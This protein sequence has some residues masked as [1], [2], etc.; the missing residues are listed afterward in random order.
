VGRI[1]L[2]VAEEATGSK[3][4]FIGEI[5]PSGLVDNI[6]ISNPGWE[7]CRLTDPT[8]NRM[9]PGGFRVHGLYGRV[10]G[11]GKGLIANEP[12]SHPDSIGTPP[13]HPPLTAF[14]G[15]PLVQ[16]GK[17]I[18]LVAVGNR[19]GGYGQEDLATLEALA[20]PI[21]QV[22]MR[23]RAEEALHKERDFTAA[24]LDT[25]GA[26]VIVLDK[27]GRITRFNKACETMTGYTEGEVLGRAFWELLIPQEDLG[28]VMRAWEALQAGNLPTKYENKW[29]A[30]DGSM[31]LIA[32]SNTAMYHPDGRLEH[33]IG[34]GIDITESRKAEAS[35]KYQALLLSQVHEGIVGADRETH[36]RYW[37]KGAEHIYG[38]T[39]EEALG[40]TT[41]ELLRPDYAPGER[42]K[43]MDELTRHGASEATVRTRH[44]NGTEVIAEVHST[45]MTDESGATS[46][47]VV[48]YRDVTERETAEEELRRTRA[49]L[50]NLIDYANAPI[51]VWDPDFKITRFN[52]AFE[53]LTGLKSDDVIDRPLDILY[54][55]ASRDQSLAHNKRTLDGERWEVVEIPI[56]KTDGSVRTVLWNSANVCDE[57]GITITATIAQGQ[58]ITERKR[59]EQELRLQAEELR[60]LNRTLTALSHSDQ[61][62]MRA[63]DEK[64]FLDEACQIIVRDCGHAMVWIGYA[65]DDAEKSVRPV[66]GAGFEDGYVE[67]L[68]ISWDDTER[69]RGPTG[70]A[71]R[72]GK[73]LACNDMLTDPSFTPWRAQAI[74]RGYASSLVLPLL[75]EG[76]PFGAISIYF[77]QP[78]GVSEDEM[79]LLTELAADVAYGIMSIRLREAHARAEHDLK[80]QSRELQQLTETLEQRVRERTAELAEANELLKAEITH[81]HMLGAAVSQAKEGMAITDA[82]GHIVYVNPA[83]EKT[84]AVSQAELLGKRYYDLLAGEGIDP[85]LGKQ[86]QKTAGAGEAWDAHLIRKQKGEQTCELD[87]MI[88]PIRDR[89]G[90]IINYL[91][92]ERDVTHEVR[93]QQNLRQAQKMEALGTLA[94]GIAHDLNNILNP[95]FINTELVLMDAALDHVT[96]RDL[97]TVLKAAERGRDGQKSSPSA[98][99][100]RRSGGPRRSVR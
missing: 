69:G 53:R 42:E 59:A 8:G 58:D 62:L 90:N 37:N 9:V 57:D 99:R 19:D 33:I 15:A 11:D 98:A 2:R 83:F 16:R 85:T 17:T 89:S 94:G 55:E 24:V 65:E 97:E 50:E 7:A 25:A 31:R 32:W 21:A 92:V 22:I 82:G 66:A 72:T 87:I 10:L 49:H 45:R 12:S 26:L 14:M 44:K 80:L 56:L 100:K 73:P 71:I 47:Y 86:A 91:V 68:D 1:C 81:S 6:A 77:R 70:T 93:L 13:G 88:T 34:T 52:H 20:E 54:P 36:I 30:R 67:T 76:R 79:K 43:I 95:I 23:R 74:A 3:F 78:G 41:K 63:Q 61:A 84:S 27:E 64:E 4:G 18:G 51:I 28:G 5:G 29:V 60:R 46:G 75:T 35:I 38:F 39:E 48:A 40:K 96:R